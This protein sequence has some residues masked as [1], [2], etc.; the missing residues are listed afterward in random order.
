M[1]EKNQL[2]I[3]I[4]SIGRRIRKARKDLDYLQ[5]Q[6]V[7]PLEISTSYLSEIENGDKRPGVPLICKMAVYHGINPNYLLIGKGRMFL[8]S[9]IVKAPEL[10]QRPEDFFVLDEFDDF[11]WFLINSKYF[12]NNMLVRGSDYFS[13][14]REVIIDR[15]NQLAHRDGG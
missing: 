4:D 8:E 10:S 2:N 11:L 9:R 7:A 1:S 13:Q 12:R 5:K 14:N 15:L 6:F 3:I